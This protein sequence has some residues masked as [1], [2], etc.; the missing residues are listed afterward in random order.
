MAIA[1]VLE[2]QARFVDRLQVEWLDILSGQWATPEEISG[3]PSV[4]L[5]CPGKGHWVALISK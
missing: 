4:E 2:A 1:V 3:G 5:I